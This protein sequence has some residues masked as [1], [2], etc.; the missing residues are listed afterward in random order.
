MN[1]RKTA[2]FVTNFL[3]YSQTFIYDEIANHKKY[4]IEVFSHNR[5]NPGSFPYDKVNALSENNSLVG[6]LEWLLYGTTTYSPTYMRKMKNGNF[7]VIHAH[8]GLGSIYALPYLKA[9]DAPLVVTYHGYDV[10]LLMTNS[11]FK[12]Q[13][14]RYWLRS[15]AM[16]KKVDRFLAAS[17]ELRDL[18]IQLG[19]PEHKVKVWRLGVDIPEMKEIP[20]RNGKNILMVGRFVEKKGFE[21]GLRGFAEVVRSGF[22]CTLNII[23][24]GDLRSRYDEIIKEAGIE[25]NVK[26]LG[27]MDHDKVL[28]TMEKMD[29]LV[30]PSVIAAN[31]D[32]ESGLI[33]AKE[34]SA[35]FVPVIGTLHGG[36]PEIIDHEKTG[37]LVDE[38]NPEQIA[39]YLEILLSDDDLRR[40]MG[41]NGRKKMEQEYNIATRIEKLEEHYDE[42]IEEFKKRKQKAK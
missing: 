38:R 17:N 25:D 40:E 21:Y 5:M 42:V 18:L 27:V 14:W 26:F 29:I 10:P 24:S 36:I 30:A 7:D 12:P 11:R 3:Q 34:A 20:E 23:G 4:D 39:K 22:D 41:S 13:N 31:G 2:L 33:V 37:F 8:F 28:E 16:F 6:K 19:A 1:K 32:R 9:A 35:R 15:K